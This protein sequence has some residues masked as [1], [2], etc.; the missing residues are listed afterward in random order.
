[1]KHQDREL[2]STR[3]CLVVGVATL[4][5]AVALTMYGSGKMELVNGLPLYD[6]GKNHLF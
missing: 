2:L 6:W 5:D 3:W 4:V 1:M